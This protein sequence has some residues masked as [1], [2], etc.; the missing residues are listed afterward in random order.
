M[1]GKKTCNSLRCIGSRSNSF[2]VLNL[3]DFFFSSL[4]LLLLLDVFWDRERKMVASHNK[5]IVEC[6]ESLMH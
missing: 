2:I 5:D 1:K 4:L 6:G 3:K